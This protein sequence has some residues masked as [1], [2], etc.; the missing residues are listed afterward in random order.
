M[1]KKKGRPGGKDKGCDPF[2]S[3]PGLGRVQRVH[4]VNRTRTGSWERHVDD[5]LTLDRLEGD[6]RR[7][8]SA[9]H[10]MARFNRL[11]AGQPAAAVRGI[12]CEV[13][14]FEGAQVLVRNEHG[15]EFPCEVRRVLKKRLAGVTAPLVVGDRVRVQQTSTGDRVIAVLE[16]RTN[17]LQRADSHNKALVHVFAANVDLLLVISSVAMPALKPALI[18][19]YLVIA[20]ADGIEPVLIVNKCDLGRI[21][22]VE[23]LYLALGYTVIATSVETGQGIEA[24]RSLLSGRSCV[25]AGQSGVGKSSLINAL[26]PEL[27]LRV[28]AVSEAQA[29]GRHTTTVSR[30]HLLTGGCRLIDTPGVRECG[31][32]GL[33]ALDLALLYRDIAALHQQCRFN[34]CRHLDEPGCAVRAALERGELAPSRYDSYLGILL[35]DLAR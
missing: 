21:E 3:R 19:R 1:A 32:T 26:Y 24:L 9:E 33:D 29:K 2:S 22:A 11:L 23:T 16:A 15:E 17:Q 31:I 13:C 20:E 27:S 25:F 6:G 12:S 10:L 35:E 30:S 5:D 4:A 34:N 7:S 14:G 28:G 8:H 18:D